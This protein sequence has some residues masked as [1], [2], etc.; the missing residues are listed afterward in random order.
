MKKII[1]VLFILF[2]GFISRAGDIKIMLITGGHS[3]DT[4]QFFQMFDELE[5]IDY[6]H[7]Q[8]PAANAKLVLDQAKD[9][10]VLVFYDMWK[11]ISNK[12]KA[13]YIKLTE[14]GKPMLFLHHSIASYQNWPEFE[15]ILGGKYFEKD[16]KVPEE[17]WSNFEHDVWVYSKVE[18]YTP[19]TEG[20]SELRFFDEI[21]GNVRISEG[22]I[23]LL[24]T[25]HP[26]SMDIIAWENHFNASTIIYLQPGHDY[27]TYEAKDYRKL[28]LQ[29][30]KFLAK[31]K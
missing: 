10:D 20:F 27:R 13:A 9:F 15:N 31:S 22:V 23:P 16:R 25:T 6:I 7:F 3:Y 4:V 2:S 24:K 1:F 18:K 21:Y 12:E 29:S 11:T 17:L 28:V 26:K 5:G 8:Q 30:I 14:Q 19:V